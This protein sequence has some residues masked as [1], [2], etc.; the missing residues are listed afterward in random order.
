MGKHRRRERK[1][2]VDGNGKGPATLGEIAVKSKRICGFLVADAERFLLLRLTG[3]IVFAD[4]QWKR[5]FDARQR[6]SSTWRPSGRHYRGVGGNVEAPDADSVSPRV[7]VGLP[8]EVALRNRLFVEDARI[9]DELIDAAN[10]RA[11]E[12]RS[13]CIRGGANSGP[14]A[15]TAV[16]A[17]HLRIEE[18][19][20]ART[21]QRQRGVAVDGRANKSGFKVEIG[22]ESDQRRA[23][24]KH[25]GVTRG[26]ERKLLV[27]LGEDCAVV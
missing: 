27:V 2:V 10:S 19:G 22:A 1:R 20:I 24:G 11:Y 16:A 15:M 3:R 18:R 13:P 8:L 9:D 21:D 5:R 25:L 17:D 4:R 26:Y 7:A 12:R 23:S 14:I 6:R